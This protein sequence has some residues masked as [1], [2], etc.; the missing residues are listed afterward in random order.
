MVLGVDQSQGGEEDIYQQGLFIPKSLAIMTV[1]YLP[2][3]TFL[4]I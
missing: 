3:S 4:Y 2:I 1:I